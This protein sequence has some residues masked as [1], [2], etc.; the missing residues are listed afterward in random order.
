MTPPPE[1]L[2]LAWLKPPRSLLTILFLVTLVSISALEWCAQ[3]TIIRVLYNAVW[4]ISQ[5]TNPT[6]AELATGGKA[7][8]QLM[9]YDQALPRVS[10]EKWTAVRNDMREKAKAS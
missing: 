10:A 8:H 5:K 3:A 2:N 4:A 9:A 6:P 1:W 7:A